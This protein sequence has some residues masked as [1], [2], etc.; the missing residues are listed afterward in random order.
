M[1]SLTTCGWVLMSFMLLEEIMHPLSE[2]WMG[3]NYVVGLLMARRSNIIFLSI[4]D[5]LTIYHCI[6]HCIYCVDW[7]TYKQK[8]NFAEKALRFYWWVTIN[9]STKK[10]KVDI[11]EITTQG[12][13]SYVLGT[14]QGEK[15]PQ[16][17]PLLGS[18]NL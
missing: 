8:L 7:V 6:Y 12:Y 5:F 10:S 9:T 17:E 4:R 13:W 2:I 3:Q 14:S 16:L 18:Y 15:T 1:E 11:F